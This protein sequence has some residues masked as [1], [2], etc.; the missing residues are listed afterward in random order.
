[1]RLSLVFAMLMVTEGVAVA[2]RPAFDV[3]SVKAC[4]DGEDPTSFR[5]SPG[6]ANLVCFPVSRLISIAYGESAN[7]HW[8]A[9]PMDAIEDKPSWIQMTYPP[10]NGYT[11]DAKST[12]AASVEVVEGPMLRALLEDRF[13]L[14]IRR[15]TRQ[16]PVYALT[17]TKGGSKLRDFDGSCTRWDT[18]SP[19]ESAATG[20]KPV[21]RAANSGKGNQR[22]VDMRGITLSTF[23]ARLG[24]YGQAG[25]DLEGP[26]VDR[27]G[28]TGSFDIHLEYGYEPI[29]GVAPR[30][31]TIDTLPSI[32]H[33]LQE[34]LGLKLERTTGPREFLVIEHVERPGDN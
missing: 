23:A 21:C 31:E 13:K 14:K 24:Q 34:Q 33:A 28:L 30:T 5:F 9:F 4:K 26:I 10:S 12:D 3:A 25:G 16:V 8:N 11:I 27:T 22:I 2:Q 17:V 1:M 29:T 20:A 32:F 18:P 6:S 19:E 7:G 15:E